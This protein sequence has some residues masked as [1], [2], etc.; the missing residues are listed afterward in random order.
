MGGENSA[1]VDRAKLDKAM[2]L[3]S[4]KHFICFT[5][6]PDE[7]AVVSHIIFGY[8]HGHE[9]GIHALALQV[10]MGIVTSNWK[11]RCQRPNTD[12]HSADDQSWC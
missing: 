1:I 12:R 2:H 6:S 10:T 9:R 7:S 5:A 11:L 4:S 8:N 3:V